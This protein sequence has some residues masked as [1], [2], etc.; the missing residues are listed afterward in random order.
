MADRRKTWK[1]IGLFALAGTTVAGMQATPV[2]AGAAATRPAD[3]AVQGGEGLLRNIILVAEGGE[4]AGGESGGGES[5]GEGGGAGVPDAGYALNSTDPN[6]FKYDARPEIAAYA[7]G[8]HAS[9]EAAVAGARSLQAAVDAL[10]A[11]PGE[12]TLAAARKAWVAARPAY[13][14]TETYRFYDGPIEE[15]EGQINAWPMN[16]AFIDYVEGNPKAGIINDPSIEISIREIIEKNQV[17]D[18]NDVTTGWHAVEFLLWGQDLDPDGPGH[19]PAS[20]YVAGKDNNDRRRAYLKDVTDQ[21]VADIATVA[22]AWAQN[23]DNYARKFLALPDREAVGRILN[24]MA[25]LAGFEFMSERLAVGLDS[26][27]QEDE[28]SCFSDTTHQDFVYDLKGIENVWNGAYNGAPGAA[29]RGLV[30]KVDPA[31]ATEVSGL[32]ADT[33]A[34]VAVLGDPWDKVLASPEGS[35]ERMRAEEAVAALQ[36]LGEGFK[37]AGAKLGVLVQIPSG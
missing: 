36:A 28:H 31:L 7:A 6:D 8:V 20:D 21:L 9:Y 19:R 27:D 30:E 5:G 12:A 13:L 2:L 16:E 15:I 29:I 18:E 4:Q 14:L 26:G 25:V 3:E 22:D 17:T 1:G 34:K 24:G 32:L 33:T 10:L 11:D 37:K 23:G 35:P